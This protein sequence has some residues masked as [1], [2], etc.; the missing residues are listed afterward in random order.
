MLCGTLC[1]CASEEKFEEDP[2]K[3]NLRQISK[4]YW[5]HLGY[6]DTPPKE[7]DLRGDV[8]SLSELDM[9]RPAAEAMISPRDNQPIVVVYGA[10]KNTPADAI[11]AYEQ[12][13]AEGT[14]W[15]VTMAQDIKE[16][17]DADFKKAKF[18]NNHKPGNK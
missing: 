6:H 11:L 2:I 4:A 8:Q 1:G 16:L 14:R 13:G 5:M 18:A 3:A 7:K 9:G 17:S 15:V 10:G 12:Q